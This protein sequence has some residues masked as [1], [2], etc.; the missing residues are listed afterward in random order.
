MN[1]A[2]SAK[3]DAAERKKKVETEFSNAKKALKASAATGML[4][5]SLV[6]GSLNSR[7]ASSSSGG[8]SGHGP[9]LDDFMGDVSSTAEPEKKK[10]KTGRKGGLRGSAG[11]GGWLKN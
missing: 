4:E 3:V 6:L 1:R 5:E 2:N 9:D 11:K 7:N 10:E 8:P